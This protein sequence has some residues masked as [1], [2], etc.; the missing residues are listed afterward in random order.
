MVEKFGC[1]AAAWG[2]VIAPALCRAGILEACCMPAPAQTETAAFQDGC[3]RHVRPPE[4][5][6]PQPRKCDSC[7]HVCDAAATPIGDS[8]RL[9]RAESLPALCEAQLAP[10]RA[11]GTELLVLDHAHA[12]G[13]NLPFRRSDLPLLI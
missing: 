11:C 12:C 3:C 9:D 6:P 2:L 5:A 1:L 7:V 10:Q 8:G 4:S 13:T